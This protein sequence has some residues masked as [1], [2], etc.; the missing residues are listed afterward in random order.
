MQ[1]LS[2]LFATQVDS[3]L[4]WLFREV[5]KKKPNQFGNLWK[6]R[7][8]LSAMFIVVADNLEGHCLHSAYEVAQPSP[9]ELSQLACLATSGLASLA[10]PSLA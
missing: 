9:A 7:A 10:Q 5:C 3:S 4:I 6:E 8:R 2:N 1:P